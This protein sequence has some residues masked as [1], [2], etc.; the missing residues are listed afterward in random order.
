MRKFDDFFNEQMKDTV[1]KEEY[2][3]LQPELDLIILGW[4]IPRR[5]RRSAHMV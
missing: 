5:L 2:E 4:G 3:K 1:F